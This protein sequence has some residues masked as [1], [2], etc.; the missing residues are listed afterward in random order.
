MKTIDMDKTLAKCFKHFAEAQNGGSWQYTVFS[1]VLIG[2]IYDG[3]IEDMNTLST[4]WSDDEII[5]YIGDTSY[6]IDFNEC[7]KDEIYEEFGVDLEYF[8]M[9]EDGTIDLSESQQARLEEWKQEQI[10]SDLEYWFE[11]GGVV[12]DM[13]G[14][15]VT[16]KKQAIEAIEEYAKRNGYEVK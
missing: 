10:Y 7:Q 2:E 15:E 12:F 11:Y 14:N 16:P 6:S 8:D 3:E 4:S 13:H 9:L 5:T 1:P